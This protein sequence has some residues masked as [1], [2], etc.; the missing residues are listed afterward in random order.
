MNDDCES[1][2]WGS[3]LADIIYKAIISVDKLLK[4]NLFIVAFWYVFSLALLGLVFVTSR[5]LI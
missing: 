2:G 1:D 4:G 5:L 3:K